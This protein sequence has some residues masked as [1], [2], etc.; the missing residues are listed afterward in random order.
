MALFKSNLIINFNNKSTLLFKEITAL[1]MYY[2]LVFLSLCLFLSVI[3]PL[4]VVGYTPLEDTTGN[5]ADLIEALQPIDFIEATPGVSFWYI[6]LDTPFFGGVL[7]IL[8]LFGKFF[9]SLLTSLF[10]NPNDLLVEEIIQ[11]VM[12]EIAETGLNGAPEMKAIPTLSLPVQVVQIVL[13]I[14]ILVVLILYKL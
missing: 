2:I 13:P 14:C 6:Q 10:P 11:T 9:I 5:A 4:G 1:L 8:F 3:T 12:L 7:F